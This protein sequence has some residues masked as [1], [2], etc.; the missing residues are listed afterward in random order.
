MSSRI[1]AWTHGLVKESAVETRKLL[2]CRIERSGSPIISR[3]L[4]TAA[5]KMTR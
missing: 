3:F 2:I 1:Q 5:I 4:Q